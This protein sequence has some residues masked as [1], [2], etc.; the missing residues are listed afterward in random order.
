MRTS[1]LNIQR[2]SF[3]RRRGNSFLVRV[4]I[5]PKLIPNWISLLNIQQHLSEDKTTHF[6]VRVE[7]CQNY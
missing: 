5:I 7:I 3:I 4:E 6:L 2:D 1:Q